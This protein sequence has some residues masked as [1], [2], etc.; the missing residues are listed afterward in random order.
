MYV[1]LND[2]KNEVM[3]YRCLACSLEAYLKSSH[4]KIPYINLYLFLILFNP[5]D[6]RNRLD[7]V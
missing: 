1:Y 6:F 5:A 7:C 4:L 2:L 3:M